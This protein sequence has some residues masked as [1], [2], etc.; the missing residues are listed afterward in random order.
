MVEDEGII[1]LDIRERLV[2]LGYNALDSVSYGEEAI[3]QVEL[4][5]PDL[6]LMD[7][8]LSGEMDG[9]EAAQH[10]Q[11][12]FNIPVAFVSAYADE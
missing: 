3:K 8:I 10:I 12:Q 1:A 4:K 2:S 6:V 7:I 11:N 5:Q 9:I